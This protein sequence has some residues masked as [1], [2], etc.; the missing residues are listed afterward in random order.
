ML[1]KL[2]NVILIGIFLSAPSFATYDL[3]K[4]SN[5]NDFQLDAKAKQV[6]SANGFVVTPGYS[7]EFFEVYES[8][9]Y[10]QIPNFIT[11][12]SILHNYHLVFDFILKKLEQE[13][14]APKLIL[15][16]KAMQNA[17]LQ[18][19]NELK[20]TEWENAAKRNVGFF[21]VANKLLNPNFAVANIV[22]NPVNKELELIKAHN[23]ITFSP[24]MNL[25]A[26]PSIIDELK[27]D[28]TQYIPRGHYSRSV[29]LQNYFKTMM[30]YGRITFRFK[31]VDEVRSAILLTLALEQNN[32]KK[33]WENIYSP[34]NYFV[35]KSDDIGFYEFSEVLKK[36]YGEKISLKIVTQDNAK[37]QQFV[38]ALETLEAPKINSM[39]I[40][41]A[42]MQ[43]D[44]AKEV[45]GLRFFG[46]R[47]TI[48]A[49]VFQ[50]LIVRNVG[51]KNVSCD[52][53]PFDDGRNLPKAL[54]IAAVMGSKTA[55][56]ILT[57]EGDF[58]YAC[59]PENLNIMQN[60]FT[61]L[62][63]MIWNQNLYW[64]WL[65]TLQPLLEPKPKNYPDFMQNSAWS[66]KDLNTFLGSWTELK[67][68]TI[69][70]AKQVYAEMGD[71]DEI[72][73]DDRG[74]VEPNVEL[75]SGLIELINHTEYG[76]Q[77][78]NLLSA[79][80]INLLNVMQQ[81]TVQLKTIAT[82]E[83][84]GIALTDK[85]YELIRSYGGQIEH[86]WL[87]AFKDEGIK[88]TA[89]LSD[90]PAAIVADVATD[91]K[92]GQVLEEAIGKVNNIYVI[93][94][95]DGK[96]KIGSGGVY[97]YYEFTM[98]LDQRLTDEKWREMLNNDKTPA[99]PAWTS[100]FIPQ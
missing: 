93:F 49:A 38:A 99:L 33:S 9:R 92:F 43:P 96:L 82:K 51:P 14:L 77:D 69:L 1:K 81:L 70:Y 76:L 23:A 32:N 2:K 58:A 36:V 25:S 17:S 15:L 55:S 45:K 41:M 22:A 79:K 94:K 57:K 46:Q 100:E 30:W 75:Y 27:E 16:S 20:N 68:D 5:L 26:N 63:P 62:S 83:L 85:E 95:Q 34:I 90:R 48:D 66:K 7:S 87:E 54:D 71:G 8:N 29:Q 4:I 59:Y 39:P 97:S 44:A 88:S 47:F 60:H 98:P 86:F 72:K 28:Y 19:Y 12:D 24:V 10:A 52:K 50:N 11:T 73:K 78:R 37:F 91:P 84:Q 89:Q 65:Y 18:Q 31:N 3:T 21:S 53:A 80:T 64:S 42:S 56:D 13:K 74:Y 6:L 61:K 67:H 40:F 35:G